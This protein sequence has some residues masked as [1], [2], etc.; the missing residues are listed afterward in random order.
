MKKYSI[1]YA[2]PPWFYNDSYAIGDNYELMKDE[3]IYNLP[4]EDI[5]NDNCV[6]FL[7]ATFPKLPEA[8]ETI[9]K[10]GFNYKTVAFVWIKRNKKSSSN[11]WG[12]G[13]WTRGNAEIVLLGIKGKIKKSN[14]GDI[15]QIINTPIQRHS[16]KPDIV[17][18][19]I[20]QLMGDLT[21]IE[22]FTRERIYGWD[23]W[24]NEVESNIELVDNKF[25][26]N[27]NITP[28]QKPIKI[29]ENLFV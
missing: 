5:C 29:D 2:D 7:W 13:N 16:K 18:D 28:I 23:S 8:I 1:I 6:L 19:K 21:R 4:I 22:L 14:K 10:W 9:K 20:V 12:L 3:D 25:I 27:K 17:R 11:F 26:E 15:H 24:G